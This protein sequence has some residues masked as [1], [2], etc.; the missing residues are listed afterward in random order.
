MSSRQE[1]DLVHRNADSTLSKISAVGAF[2]RRLFP[3][4]L[5]F[6]SDLFRAA[7][8]SSRPY[9]SPSLFLS[10]TSRFLSFTEQ[11]LAFGREKL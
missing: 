8:Q 3:D 2:V 6:S 5:S 10:K 1:H 7:A 9:S 11:R 4:Q